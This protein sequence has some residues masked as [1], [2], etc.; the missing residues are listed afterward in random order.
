MVSFFFRF[1]L[2]VSVT[3]LACLILTG[4]YFESQYEG[5]LKEEHVRI[6]KALNVILESKLCNATPDKAQSIVEELSKEYSYHIELQ[7]YADLSL[8]LKNKIG[9]N[10]FYVN[11]H[12]GFIT[13]LI[14]VYYV[15]PCS[16]LMLK[17]K[18]K[19]DYNSFYNIL[20]GLTLVFVLIAF[21]IAVLALAW[22]IFKHIN[23][24]LNSTYAIASGNFK[25]KVDE[26]A[27]AP[28]D[29]LAFAINY[30][31]NQISELIDEQEMVTSAASHEL[32]TPL[33]R[34]NFVLDIAM[35]TKDPEVL[36]ANLSQIRN[37]LNE[38][39]DLV[40]EILGYSKFKFSGAELKRE[41][42]YILPLLF[43]MRNKLC[44]LK[45]DI[46]IEI[47][48]P[49]DLQLDG[50]EKSVQRVIVNLVRNAQ[51]YAHSLIKVEIFKMDTEI[52][53]NV[54]DDGPGIPDAMK[55]EVLKPFY[56]IDS[57]RSRDTGGAGLGLA[58]VN[59]ICLLHKAKLAL[60]DNEYGGLTVK[61]SFDAEIC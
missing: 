57:S 6:A 5:A 46:H 60:Q 55:E 24:M 21:A 45:P 20:F 33:M 31:V 1:Y 44:K 53:I 35:K 43:R 27:P 2:G 11:I 28:L 32:N 50:C 17:F 58:I 4:L 23:Y 22:P 48:C 29:K 12:S 49:N 38:L 25:M 9:M 26:S 59:K 40:V 61:M 56:R 15:Q 52:I 41:P 13:D 42:F 51:K 30:V 19:A 10:S 36:K 14:E 18:P 39:E 47:T 37:D 8:D 54:V 3:L 16:E 7:S 34:M